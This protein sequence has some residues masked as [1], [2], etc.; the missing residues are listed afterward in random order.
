MQAKDARVD[1]INC[2]ESAVP[3]TK[4]TLPDSVPKV[5]EIRISPSCIGDIIGPGRKT[6]DCYV[7][8]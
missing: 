6:V 5:R 1:A 7:N 8:Y 4:P 2:I 3:L